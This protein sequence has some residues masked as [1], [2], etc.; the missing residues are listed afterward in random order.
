MVGA[1]TN[2]A[3]PLMLWWSLWLKESLSGTSQPLPP[4]KNHCF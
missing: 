1:M 3:G 2:D 4:K